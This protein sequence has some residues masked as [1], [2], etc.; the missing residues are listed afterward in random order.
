VKDISPFL[1]APCG[2]DGIRLCAL[3]ADDEISFRPFE[4]AP[5]G[6]RRFTRSSGDFIPRGIITLSRGC[7]V[8]VPLPGLSPCCYSSP[9]SRGEG[10]FLSWPVRSTGLPSA[11]RLLLARQLDCNLYKNLCERV[12]NGFAGRRPRSCAGQRRHRTSITW[13]PESGSF[14]N[15]SS[16]PRIFHSCLIWPL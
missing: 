15:A 5:V 3:P 10:T 12:V 7:V 16:L 1:L 4:L 13:K 2:V 14:P 6:S 9:P 8:S 11:I